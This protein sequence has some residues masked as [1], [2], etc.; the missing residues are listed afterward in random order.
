MYGKHLWWVSQEFHPLKLI[1]DASF[2]RQWYFPSPG[3][4]RDENL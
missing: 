4:S 1:G 3:R 2:F